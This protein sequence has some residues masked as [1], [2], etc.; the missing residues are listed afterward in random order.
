MIST[1]T[2]I[3]RASA[4]RR[5]T[6]SS[7]LILLL[8]AAGCGGSA[9]NEVGTDDGGG[10]D[11]TIDDGGISSDALTDADPD[12]GGCGDTKTDPANCGSCGNACKPGRVCVGGTCT[13]P[14]Y[15]SLCGD[16]C[17]PTTADAKN[18]GGCG[19]TCP[20]G[21]AC[22]AGECSSTCLSGLTAC[23][24]ACV[25]LSTDN[26]HCGVCGTKCATGTACVDGKCRPA[27]G[28]PTTAP[29]CPE[30][31]PAIILDDGTGK[32]PCVGDVAKTTFTWG[33]CSCTNV[34]SSSKLLVDG[35]DSTKGPYKPGE[36]GGGVGLNGDFRA[37][38]ISDVWG[39]LWASSSVGMTT[40]NDTSVHNELHVGGP[41]S[42]KTCD[43]TKDAWVV[44]NVTGG[45]LA[46][47]KTLHLPTASMIAGP[48][49]YGTLVREPVA[50]PPPCACREK[51]LLPIAAWIAS[52]KTT[53][54]NATIALDP[55]TYTKPTQPA[56]LDLPCGRYYLDAIDAKGPTAIVAHGRTALFIGGDVQSSTPLSIT[57]IPGASLD[58]FIGGT[59]ITSSELKV[60]SP[61]FPALTR[62]YVNGATKLTFSS[63]GILAGNFYAAR[64]PI[65]WSGGTEIYGSVFAGDFTS[66]TPTLIHYDRNVVTVGEDCPKKPPV[67]DAG[68]PGCGSCKDCG[69]QACI[70]GKCSECTSS[71]QC[72][73]PLVCQGGRCVSVIK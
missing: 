71:A 43:V 2:G 22:S 40:S 52:A 3:A 42:T 62:V 6:V 35:F 50:V 68:P 5:T 23:A 16:V 24:G 38:S 7:L 72:C 14:S 58:V 19:K 33:L 28:L 49:T 17:I 30:G 29:T 15:Q 31:G 13:C 44:G 41:L 12:G 48:V 11:A 26:D 25:D 69:N 57:L 55:A 46:I 36:L 59:I 70:D 34:K 37:S 67:G 65:F 18:C 53:N 1:E 60:G 61:N 20:A 21:Q 56:R 32:K 66:S 27:T 8:A 54:D 10:L 4:M 64:A 51:D 63:S 39:T 9:D 45:P 73:P 47:A